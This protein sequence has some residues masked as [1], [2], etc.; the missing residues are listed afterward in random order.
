[1]ADEKELRRP[2]LA[3]HTNE[4]IAT[5]IFSLTERAGGF[6]KSILKVPSMSFSDLVL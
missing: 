4:C 5:A 6:K 1:M 2:K 3:A